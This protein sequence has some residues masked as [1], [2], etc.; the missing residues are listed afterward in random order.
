MV[1]H[2]HYENEN[3]DMPQLWKRISAKN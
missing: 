2:Y 3:R 1:I